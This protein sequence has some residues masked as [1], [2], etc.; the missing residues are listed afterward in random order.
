MRRKI[1]NNSKLIIKVIANKN[2]KQIET[3]SV[4]DN[5]KN[6]YLSKE[7][8]QE[9]GIKWFLNVEHLKETLNWNLNGDSSKYQ[10][11]WGQ[12]DGSFVEGIAY[13]FD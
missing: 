3:I 10:F 8:I 5:R 1:L 12:R 9:R 11:K 6:K 7:Y 2:T 4:Y 13:I